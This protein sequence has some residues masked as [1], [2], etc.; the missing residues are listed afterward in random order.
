MSQRFTGK[1]VLIT[2]AASGIGLSTA[3]AFAREGAS[4]AIADRNV[5]AAREVAASIAAESG[6]VVAIEVDVADFASCE[7]M[8]GAVLTRFGSLDIAFNNAG[9]PGAAA[10]SFDEIDVADWD[11]VMAINVSGVFH[12]MKAEVP[13]LRRSGGGVIINAASSASFMAAPGLSPYVTSKHAVAGLTKSAALD[14][15]GDGIR[16]NAICPGMAATPMMLPLLE[17]AA[18]AAALHAQTPIAR[19]A[20]PEEIAEGVLFLASDAASYAV[21]T[22]LRLDGGLTLG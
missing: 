10:G 16:V 17:D 3:R 18:V 19:L 13:V 22:L 1:V 9:V 7:A 12:C 6:S 21:G 2:G 4:V 20:S 5:A 14:L 15:I 8:V 11:R